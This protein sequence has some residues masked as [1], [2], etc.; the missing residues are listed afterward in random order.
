MPC[1]FVSMPIRLSETKKLDVRVVKTAEY[2]NKKEKDL[3]SRSWGQHPDFHLG[4]EPEGNA[5]AGQLPAQALTDR[6]PSGL[7]PALR[8]CGAKKLAT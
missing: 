2:A 8:W 3:R 7:L 4:E 6:K 5:S 1:C